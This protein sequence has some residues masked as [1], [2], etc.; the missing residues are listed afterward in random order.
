[1]LRSRFVRNRFRLVGEILSSRGGSVLDV[2]ARDRVLEAYVNPS[3][4]R[5]QSS[6]VASGHDYE[7]DLERALPFA[8]RQFDHVVAL[9]V[10]EHV[11]GIHLAFQELGR[12]ADVSMVIAL[13]NI[14][15]ATRRWMFL[16]KGSLGGKYQLLPDHQGDR[17]RWV[18]TYPEVYRFVDAQARSAG[19][20]ISEAHEE[21]VQTRRIMRLLALGMLRLGFPASLLCERVVFVLERNAS[22]NVLSPEA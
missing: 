1:L 6:D 12:T 7:V 11:E 14:A 21:V 19:F 9:D 20:E 4:V 2:G 22:P 15:V 3:V 13:P 18:T 5:Y 10:L 8:D 16:S 17:H